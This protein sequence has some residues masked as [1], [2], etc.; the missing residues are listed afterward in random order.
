MGWIMYF[1]RRYYVVLPL[2]LFLPGRGKGR[3]KKLEEEFENIQMV[4][5]QAAVGYPGV[6][7]RNKTD[8]GSFGGPAVDF[9]VAHKNCVFRPQVKNVKNFSN[10][11]GVGFGIPNVEGGNDQ[12]EAGAEGKSVQHE[13]HR[14]CAVGVYGPEHPPPFQGVQ[15]F[16]KIRLHL[17]V[18]NKV[19]GVEGGNKLVRSFHQIRPAGEEKREGF[20]NGVHVQKREF[21]G[22]DRRPPQS[23]ANLVVESLVVFEGIE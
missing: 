4:F 17:H 22:S 2:N 8:P 20:L 14:A 18:G 15:R 11:F 9:G 6:L 10:R 13:F 12:V 1:I 5:E 23:R 3:G 16:P 7:V 19:M 21:L